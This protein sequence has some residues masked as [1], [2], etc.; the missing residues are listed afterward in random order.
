[1]KRLFVLALGLLLPWTAP[2]FAVEIKVLSAGAVEPGLHKAVEQFK[3][4]SG[5]QV[6]IEFN[7]APQIGK[8][9]QDGY[10]ADVVIAPLAVLK[11]HT[12]AGKIA[13]DSQVVLGKVGIGIVVRNDA[14][15]PK[16]A[17]SDD[18]K[19]EL[20]AAD[21]IVFNV[22]STGLYLERLFERLGVGA[23]IKDKSTRPP[24][25]EQVMQTVVAGKGRQIGFGPITEIKLFEGKG[26]KF[27]G[28]L[29]A[30]LQNYTTYA[31]APMT[32]AP[33]REAANAFVAHLQTAE[34]K[35]L[36][37]AAGIE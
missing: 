2:A 8:R 14:P 11:P 37:S 21:S 12:D 16:I 32:N 15:A 28:P 5:Q 33:Q 22:A 30:D 18:I 34:T 27:V 4:S 6:T 35:Q 26:V 24:S 19:A 20:L 7:T 29:P 9:L 23:Q 1:M 3:Q 13:G 17:T 36:F 10:V 31:A 25:G